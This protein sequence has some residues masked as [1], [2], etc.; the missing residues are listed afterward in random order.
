MH[1]AEQVH[2][3]WVL[4][5]HCT[6]W[7]LYCMVTVYTVWVLCGLCTVWVLYGYCTVCTSCTIWESQYGSKTDTDMIYIIREC[8]ST[9]YVGIVQGVSFSLYIDIGAKF[10]NTQKTGE[11]RL[12]RAKYRTV[13]L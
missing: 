2:T 4:Y 1:L 12:R 3:V 8:G 11:R 5:G 10:Q 7:V 13:L 9:L 6:V